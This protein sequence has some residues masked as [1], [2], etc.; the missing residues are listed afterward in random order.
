MIISTKK[1]V[2]GKEQY[3]IRPP[4]LPSSV[5]TTFTPSPAPRPHTSRSAAVG[6]SYE[7]SASAT[8]FLSMNTTYFPMTVQEGTLSINQ[9]C[10]TVES[11]AFFF[12]YSNG[13]EYFV[14]LGNT[15]KT[16]KIRRRD[17]DRRLVIFGKPLS[18]W[19]VNLNR[20]LSLKGT[21]AHHGAHESLLWRRKHSA[22][23]RP[24][25]KPLC[26]AVSM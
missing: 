24:K 14:V 10:R 3:H 2:L 13:K 15:A 4:T 26:F 17:C 20:C 22:T 25:G 11:A 18:T 23:D 19:N 7:I 9:H 16:I 12:N 21:I 6:I 5:S 1:N 8:S